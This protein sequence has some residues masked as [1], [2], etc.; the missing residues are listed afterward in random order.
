MFTL[1]ISNTILSRQWWI[2]LNGLGLYWNQTQIIL[3]I[4]IMECSNVAQNIWHRHWLLFCFLLC[5]VNTSLSAPK[6]KLD[7]ISTSGWN[8]SQKSPPQATKG[9]SPAK[10]HIAQALFRGFGWVWPECWGVWDDLQQVCRVAET[11]SERGP[12][13]HLSC[14]IAS[15]MDRKK[16]FLGHEI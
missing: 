6:T 13:L 8:L 15:S 4:L 1:C 12:Q 7:P 9:A 5:Q 2:R 3:Q 14:S 11:I 16:F 10:L